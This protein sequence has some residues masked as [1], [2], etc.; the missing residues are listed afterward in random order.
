M[1]KYLYE[2]CVG[3][4]LC[5]AMSKAKLETDELGFVHPNT[6]DEEW[7]DQVC[8]AGGRQVQFMDT[9]KIWGICENAY[10]GWSANENVRHQAS[11]GG[12]LTGIC[13]YLLATKQIDAVIHVNADKNVPYKTKVQISYTQEEIIGA[14]GSRYSISHPL[15]EFDKLD[16]SRKYAFIGKPC[17][18]AAL[19]NY[20]KNNQKAKDAFVCLL[21]FFCAGLP[22]NSAQKKLLDSMGCKECVSL[23]YRG[24]GWPGYTTAI[25]KNGK[26]Y[27]M[28]YDDSWGKILGRD[29]MKMCRFC[30]DGIGETADIACADYWYITD[31]GKPDFSEHDGRNIIFARSLK[32]DCIVKS[33]IKTGYLKAE[34][35]KDYIDNLQILQKYQYERR[36]T[37]HAKLSALRTMGH[38]SPQYSLEACKKYA[39]NVPFKERFRIFAGTIKRILKRKI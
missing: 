24:N 2:Y 26:N 17:D 6:G 22:S 39:A 11:S 25:D 27:S 38:A 35:H 14:C 13:L 23:K 30:L 5:Q 31:D 20:L 1:K 15:S 32:G 3:C 18:V 10:V 19:R 21:S 12:C 7:L 4:G 37:M 29:I 33:S 8:P 16:L 28:S 34:V 9:S 36:T